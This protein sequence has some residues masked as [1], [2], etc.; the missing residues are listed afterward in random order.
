[1]MF[2]GISAVRGN[3]VDGKL[4]PIAVTGNNRSHIFPQVPTLAE[5][6]VP[7]PELNLGTWW[8]LGGPRQTPRDVLGRINQ[9]VKTATEI[10]AIKDKLAALNIRTLNSTPEEF[11]KLLRD[12]SASYGELIKRANISIGN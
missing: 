2:T 11:S 8:G 3:I 1:M 10:G 9:A 6:G 12:E 7:I 5:A 4:I